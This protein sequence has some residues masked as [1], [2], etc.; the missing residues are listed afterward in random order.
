VD[1]RHN[2]LLKGALRSCLITSISDPESD[3]DV[4]GTWWTLYR[5]GNDVVVHNQILLTEVFGNS[6]NPD[7]TYAHIADRTSVSED[8]A[9]ISEWFLQ[10]D[11]ISAR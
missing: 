10:F 1:T 9:A 4:F 6:F 7:D 8:G 5:E 2:R 11:S 3:A